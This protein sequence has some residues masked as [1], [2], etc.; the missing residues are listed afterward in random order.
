MKNM[1]DRYGRLREDL[2]DL[3]I[4][5]LDDTLIRSIDHYCSK[6]DL[7]RIDVLR[8]ALWRWLYQEY[9]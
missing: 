7:K 4:K 6:N 1:N 8:I 5:N 2:V 3:V 9:R